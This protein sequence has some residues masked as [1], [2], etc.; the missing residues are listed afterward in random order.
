MT[1]RQR[2][3]RPVPVPAAPWRFP[4]VRQQRLDNGLTVLACD[5]PGQDV[6]SAEFIVGI[7]LALEPRDLEGVMGITASALA[8]GIPGLGPVDFVHELELIGATLG[9][10]AEHSGLRITVDVPGPHLERALALLTAALRE[11]LLPA[12]SVDRLV[13][14]R[15]HASARNRADAERRSSMELHTAV[16]APEDRR[17]RPARGTADTVRR[18]DRD[19]VADFHRAFVRPAVT[20]VAVAGDLTRYRADPVLRRVLG[21][22]DGA[23]GALEF[24]TPPPVRTGPAVVLVDRPEAVQTRLLLGAAAP[25]RTSPDWDALLIGNHCLGGSVN[26]RL[27]R[28]LRETKGYTYGFHSRL[29][30]V[31]QRSLAVIT[32]AVETSATAAALGDV[33][34]ILHDLDQADITEQE[35][36]AAVAQIVDA[37]PLRYLTASDVAEELAYLALDRRDPAVLPD[38]FL[39]TAAVTT[40][41][42][43][44]VLRAAFPVDRM[45]TVAVGNLAA[46][47]D[48]V[49]ESAR[50]PVLVL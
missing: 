41:E 49:V 32:G 38:A 9:V 16:F 48:E 22:W 5:L 25:G 27:D 46:Y 47:R 21:G 10:G 30:A 37:A 11:P 20:T 17:A 15:V 13:R 7:P 35:R 29:L 50:G 34:R 39:R 40:A 3:A 28:E 26:A 18:I 33:N 12:G 44:A 19:A 14:S 4:D 24:P 1:T 42:A 23:P 43:S 36:A 31:P 2:P 8:E 45:V 6:L